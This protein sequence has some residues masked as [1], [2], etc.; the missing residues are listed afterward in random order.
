MGTTRHP[1]KWDY[2]KTTKEENDVTETPSDI[3]ACNRFGGRNESCQRI[4]M[5]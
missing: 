2:R 5:R 1:S 4:Y 3:L